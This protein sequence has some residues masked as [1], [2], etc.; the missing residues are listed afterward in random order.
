MSTLLIKNGRIITADQDYL[1]DIFVDKGKITTIFEKIDS[2]ADRIINAEEN[3]II[4][5]GI[6]AHT[7]LDMPLGDF[8]STDN[9][10]SGTIAA[11]IGGTTTIIDFPTQIHNQSLMEAIDLWQKKAEGQACIDYGFHLI[12]TNVQQAHLDDLKTLVRDGITSF[13]LFM[14]YPETLMLDD[15]AIF[16]LMHDAQTLD[17]VVSVHAENGKVIDSL[18]RTT[19]SEGKRAPVYHALTRPAVLEGEAVNRAIALAQLTGVT[20]YIVH[21]STGEGLRHV[22][23]ARDQGLPVFAETCPQYLLTSIED[24]INAGEY[25]S[26]GYVFT[27]P[28]REKENQSKLWKA[29]AERYIQVVATDHCPF[30]LDGQ[31]NTAHSDFSKIPNG[32]PGIENRL[33]LMFEKGVNE[34]R[35]N[36]NRWVEVCSTAPAKIF[37]I[38]PQKGT[39]AVGSDADLVIWDPQKEHTI[40]AGTHHMQVDYNLYEGMKIKG[41]AD[42]V[43]SRGEIIVENGSYTGSIGRG[44]YLKRSTFNGELV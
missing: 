8:F 11:A 12:I 31:K 19:L 15:A 40:S 24:M 34:G 35:I 3:Y 5:G 7:H 21:L 26:A 36:L 37:G 22:T 27:P 39:I 42:T 38:Y 1:A 17:A 20:V 13:K 43:I 44:R 18:V 6:D 16:R 32:A 30:N 28:P 25:D 10:E 9:F 41:N 33:Q 23:E 4:P 2:A 29:L 14:A